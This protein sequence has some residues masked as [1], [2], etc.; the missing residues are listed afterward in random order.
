[1]EPLV[2][3]DYPKSMKDLLKERLP[4]FTQ[5]EKILINGS[6]DFIGINYYTSRYVKSTT[7]NPNAPVHYMNDSL[8]IELG[9][10]FS[11]KIWD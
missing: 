1:M 3:G 4:S 5:E 6:F 8:A 2:F 9:I 7:L 10:V 11:P